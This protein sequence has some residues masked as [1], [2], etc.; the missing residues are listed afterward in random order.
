LLALLDPDW[1]CG[2]VSTVV[3]VVFFFSFLPFFAALV[4]M[5]SLDVSTF[6]WG[7]FTLPDRIRGWIGCGSW[8]GT[9]SWSATRMGGLPAGWDFGNR[10]EEEAEEN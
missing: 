4:L 6:G 3:V 5:R 7:F 8:K 9:G 10:I 1:R 2:R